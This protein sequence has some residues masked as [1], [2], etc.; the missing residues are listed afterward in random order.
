M[1]PLIVAVITLVGFIGG[2]AAGIWYEGHRP[3]P[4][5]PVPFMSEFG[6]PL[7]PPSHRPPVN[8]KELV[9][10]IEA[11][12]PQLEAFRR[13]MDEIGSQF[14]RD[15]DLLLNPE[16]KAKHAAE[17]RRRRASRGTP[18]TRPLSDDEITRIM[19]DQAEWTVL[20]DVVI[21]FRL[22]RLTREFK[23]DDG[24]REKVRRLLLT[25]RTQFLEL[26]DSSPPPSVGLSRLAQMVERLKEP[27]PASAAAPTGAGLH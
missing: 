11:L 1:R 21:P 26:V 14:D 23:L 17:L 3:L 27:L 18:D 16:Q 9:A 5:P 12:R 13:R 22:D 2:V 7:P 6:R 24:Q 19:R 10:R 8:R 15:F 25:R 4:P 20:G